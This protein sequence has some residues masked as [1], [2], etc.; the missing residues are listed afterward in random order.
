MGTGKNYPGESGEIYSGDDSI[1][2]VRIN[3]SPSVTEYFLF[4]MSRITI[5]D[6]WV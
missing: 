2:E 4:D 5:R 1:R 3:P 6:K